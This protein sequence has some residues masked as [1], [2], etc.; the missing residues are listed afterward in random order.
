M[1]CISIDENGL[2]D[3]IK[4]VI[5]DSKPAVNNIAPS[6]PPAK[7]ERRQSIESPFELAQPLYPHQCEAVAWMLERESGANAPSRGG[8]LADEQGLGKTVSAIAL[9]LAAR[10]LEMKA[11]EKRRARGESLPEEWGDSPWGVLVVAP[12]SVATQWVA[13]LKDKVLEGYQPSVYLHHGQGRTR[14]PFGLVDYD[15][16]VTTY[17]VLVSEAAAGK[18]GG[19]LSR[20][21]W[22]RVFLDEA[23]L[24]RNHKTAMAKAA[25]QLHAEKRWCLTGTTVHNTVDDLW[26]LFQFLQYRFKGSYPLVQWQI[27][28][29]REL[30]SLNDET[31]QNKFKELDTFLRPILL[32]RTKEILNLPP[33]EIELRRLEFICADEQQF[34]ASVQERAEVEIRR[35]MEQATGRNLYMNALYHLLRLRQAC[36]HPNLVAL[37]ET[38]G[39]TDTELDALLDAIRS[40]KE[41]SVVLS[42]PC[43]MQSGLLEK[44]GPSNPVVLCDSCSGALLVDDFA[45]VV[46][47]CQHVLCEDCSGS[48]AVPQCDHC[49]AH[50]AQLRWDKDIFMLL[51]HI[52]S[53]L[54]HPESCNI[55]ELS[56]VR[57]EVHAVLHERFKI[58]GG[59][60]SVWQGDGFS[61]SED[62]PLEREVKPTSKLVDGP[63]DTRNDRWQ[64]HS[65]KIHALLKEV[66]ELGPGDKAIVFSNWTKVCMASIG[67]NIVACLPHLSFALTLVCM[68]GLSA[69]VVYA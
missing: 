45:I 27:E 67:A 69:P 59:R 53:P 66:R 61:L 44:L 41:K 31:R 65:T 7:R 3:D 19:P 22:R 25:L 24:I 16:V 18:K 43:D 23:H 13:E 40:G 68:L 36:C 9:C 52:H 21:Q 20:V 60:A 46:L 50:L 1:S 8:I 29:K 42:L 2:D 58:A 47:R 63:G 48:F 26:T 54:A 62:G 30:Q 37:S 51:A 57:R 55:E 35:L 4:P 6:L 10:S 32:R 56:V 38:E 34:Y 11:R 49:D 5:C 14:S 15:V 33:R 64:R 39:Y 17:G 12:L 28:W